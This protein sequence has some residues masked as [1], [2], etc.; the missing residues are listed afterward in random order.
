MTDRP[1]PHTVAAGAAPVEIALSPDRF[2]ALLDVHGAALDIWPEAERAGAARLVAASTEAR[3][4]LEDA[5]RLDLAL[6]GLQPPPPSDLLRARL[7]R[8][9]EAS[10]GSP[11]QRHPGARILA[12]S[13][14]AAALVGMVLGGAGILIL[15]PPGSNAGVAVVVSDTIDGTAFADAADTTLDLAASDLATL[16]LVGFDMFTEDPENDIFSAEILAYDLALE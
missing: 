8:L 6:D 13:V 11:G 10:V 1:D 3:R 9:P 12:A 16:S 15:R 14:A 7:D 5:K 4:L 2:R